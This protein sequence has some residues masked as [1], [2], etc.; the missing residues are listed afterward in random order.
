[1]DLRLSKLSAVEKQRG[2]GSPV[3][4]L[5]SCSTFGGAWGEVTYVSF[6]N[7][8]VADFW[9]SAAEDSGVTEIEVI[10]PLTPN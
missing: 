7:V 2:F 9:L 3:A 4:L 5:D 8:T 10:F 6:S 1:M